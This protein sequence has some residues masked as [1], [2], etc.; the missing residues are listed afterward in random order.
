MAPDDRSAWLPRCQVGSAEID[1]LGLTYTPTGLTRRTTLDPVARPPRV[2]SDHVHHPPRVIAL[3][4]DRQTRVTS[5]HADPLPR[6]IIL[7]AAPRPPHAET[8]RRLSTATALPPPPPLPHRLDL[9]SLFPFLP[10]PAVSPRDSP[11]TRRLPARAASRRRSSPAPPRRRP[12]ASRRQC[13]ACP[14]RPPTASR[15]AASWLLWFVGPTGGTRHEGRTGP[16]VAP[17]RQVVCERLGRSS[18]S[19]PRSHAARTTDPRAALS[20]PNTRGRRGDGAGPPGHGPD[21]GAYRP[22]PPASRPGMA[23]GSPRPPGGSNQVRREPT[24][25]DLADLHGR[26]SA[27]QYNANKKTNFLQFLHATT[28]PALPF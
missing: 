8:R 18:A 14:C 9:L 26:C 12:A 7:H 4:V 2:P 17:V 6:V 10:F 25:N 28:N 16:P 5:H 3:S 27:T 19:R 22:P 23:V 13:S 15:R 1:R 20:R 21:V 24:E 11:T